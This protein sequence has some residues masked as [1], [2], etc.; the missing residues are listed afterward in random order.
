MADLGPAPLTE[1]RQWPRSAA[2]AAFPALPEGVQTPIINTYFGDIYGTLLTISGDS[3]SYEELYKTAENLKA[4]L[5]FSV[6]QIG[7][8]DISGVQSEVIY[9]K[10]RQWKTFT[11]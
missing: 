3:Y 10:S 7:R 9:V 8:I 11:I 4:K 5:L 2:S 6:P 1:S